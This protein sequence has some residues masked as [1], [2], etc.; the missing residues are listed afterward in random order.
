MF[1]TARRCANLHPVSR[2]PPICLRWL[3]HGLLTPCAHNM[4]LGDGENDVAVGVV[5]D[6]RERTLVSGEK[7]RPHVCGVCRAEWAVRRVGGGLC[8]CGD[9]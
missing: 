4:V 1:L 2:G 8:S 9:S 7:N 5:F 6:L 3:L